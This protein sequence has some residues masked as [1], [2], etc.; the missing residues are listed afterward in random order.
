VALP[1][2]DNRHL[3]RRSLCAIAAASAL[4]AAVPGAAPARS[5]FDQNGMWIWEMNKSSGGSTNAIISKAR[6]HHVKTVFVKSGDARSSPPYWAQFPQSVG[7][8]KAGG[9]R[10]CAWQYVYGDHPKDEAKISL[11]AI[12][13]GADCFVID[14]EMQYE[15]R[16]SQARTYMHKLRE[17]A[18]KNYPIGLT[19]FPY[20]DFHPAFPYSVFLGPGGAQFNV[21]QVYWKDI[22]DTVGSSLGHTYRWNLPYGRPINPLGQLYVGVHGG[23]S[24]SEI[25]RFRKYSRA[26]GA[27]GVSWWDWQEASSADW[28]AIGAPLDA[29]KGHVETHFTTLTHGADNDLV[30]WAQEHLAG[31]GQST[32]VDGVFDSDTERAVKHFQEGAGLTADGKI[33]TDTWAALL[34]YSPRGGSHAGLHAASTA[35]PRNARLPAKRYEIPPPAARHP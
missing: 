26:E 25:L 5:T 28:S 20:V 29:F 13:D 19:S 2:L 4:A 12:R 14:A 34:S 15:H 11:K 24:R 22:G 27:G 17:G 33:D 18:G 16:Y 1:L 7:A 9:L 23:P 30:L 10:V 31:A 8:L 3:L 35:E 21:P 6:Q 32:P